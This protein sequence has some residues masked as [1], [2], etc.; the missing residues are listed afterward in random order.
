MV[1]DEPARRTKIIAIAVVNGGRH[2][3]AS[4]AVTSPRGRR[5]RAAVNANRK[6]STVPARPTSEAS[7]RLFQNARIWC[8]S[9]STATTP[10]V[11]KFPLSKSTR[12]NNIASG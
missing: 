11:V 7:R 3:L 4:I 6:P 8:L 5:A 12:P 10:T 1:G 9:V 2:A